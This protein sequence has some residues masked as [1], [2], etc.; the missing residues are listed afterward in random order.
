MIRNSHP[1]MS[2]FRKLALALCFVC[3][4]TAANVAAASTASQVTILEISL[5]PTIGNYVFIRISPV[6]TLASCANN[7]YWQ[8]TL[9]LN[10]LSLANQ[11]YAASL[12]AQM[13]GKTVTISGTG[14]CTDFYNVESANALN[15]QS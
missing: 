12:A 15:V 14:T 5:N 10:T 8:Y 7:G 1:S 13:A 3:S 2:H 4:A 6:P 11:E 9:N